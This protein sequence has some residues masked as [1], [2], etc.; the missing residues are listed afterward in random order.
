MSGQPEGWFDCTEAYQA[1]QSAARQYAEWFEQANRACAAWYAWWQAAYGIAP[2]VAPLAGGLS[3]W[4][5]TS[6]NALPF[7]GVV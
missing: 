1:A 3:A 5:W 2:G 7:A 6:Q 4:W